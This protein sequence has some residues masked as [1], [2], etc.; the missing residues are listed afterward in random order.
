[1]GSDRLVVTIA[2]GVC[3]GACSYV[4]NADQFAAA[5]DAACRAHGEPGT[6]SYAECRKVKERIGGCGACDRANPVV[7]YRPPEQPAAVPVARRAEEPTPS[8]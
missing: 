7:D 4:L 6:P 5:D 3:L 1:M 8:P 2:A